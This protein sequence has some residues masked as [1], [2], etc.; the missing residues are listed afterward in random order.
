MQHFVDDPGGHGDQDQIGAG[1]DPVVALVMRQLADQAAVEFL[2][3]PRRQRLAARQVLLDARRQGLCGAP[4]FAVVVEDDA[5]AAD[6]HLRP[7]GPVAVLGTGVALVVA[8]VLAG[9]GEQGWRAG[10]EGEAGDGC[11]QGASLGHVHLGSMRGCS[12]C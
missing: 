9:V 11:D 12:L 6:I 10:D 2:G 1:A 5:D 7:A 8:F 4:V 3:D